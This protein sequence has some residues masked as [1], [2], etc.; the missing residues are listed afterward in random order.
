LFAILSA[1]YTAGAC[2]TFGFAAYIEGHGCAVQ[3]ET[4]ANGGF[5]LI[6]KVAACAA[7]LYFGVAWLVS[8][9]AGERGEAGR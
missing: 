5:A 8:R 4:C 7:I 2:L 6:W 3:P 1:L 9:F